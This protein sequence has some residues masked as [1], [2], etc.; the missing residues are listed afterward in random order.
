MT[1]EGGKRKFVALFTNDHFEGRQL[2]STA[3][4][5]LPK[6]TDGV[7]CGNLDRLFVYQI[8]EQI[9]EYWPFWAI[10]AILKP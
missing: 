5:L 3:S 1:D 8:L 6:K 9:H 7:F 4:L 2:P 10:L